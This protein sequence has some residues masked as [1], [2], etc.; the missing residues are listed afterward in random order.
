MDLKAFKSGIKQ[1][2]EL[3]VV[4]PMALSIPKQLHHLAQILV[5]GG[6]RIKKKHPVHISVGD[7]DSF[8]HKLDIRVN[9]DKD[10]SDLALALSLIPKNIKKVHLVG[11]LGGREDHELINLGE[12]HY[13]LSHHKQIEVLLWDRQKKIYWGLSKGLYHFSHTG[14]FSLFSFKTNKLSMKGKCEYQLKSK[15]L[16]AHSSQGLSNVGFGPISIKCEHPLFVI[17]PKGKK[18]GAKN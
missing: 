9:P 15:S 11:F 18:L 14:Y 1:R 12:I 10:F 6:T 8:E 3:I 5:D 7:G 17:F 16:K 4:G 2:K 13:F